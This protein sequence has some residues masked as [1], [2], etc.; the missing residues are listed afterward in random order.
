MLHQALLFAL[1]LTAVKWNS[2]SGFQD[3][4]LGADVKVAKWSH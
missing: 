1:V 4:Q 2:V 3:N